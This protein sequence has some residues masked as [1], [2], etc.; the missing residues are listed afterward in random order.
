MKSLSNVERDLA[1]AETKLD[2]LRKKDIKEDIAK[3]KEDLKKSGF[4]L[5]IKNVPYQ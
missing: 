3:I 2:S 4:K 5:E 1:D